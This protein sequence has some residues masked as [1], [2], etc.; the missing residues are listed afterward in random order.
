MNTTAETLAA[1]AEQDD[2]PRGTRIG[3]RMIPLDDLV[4]HPLNS[5]VMPEDLQAEARAHIKKSGRYPFL[6]VGSIRTSA[7]STAGWTVTIASPSSGTSAI[8]GRAAIWEVNDREALPSGHAQP[9]QDQPR[10]ALSLPRNS[11]ARCPR[12]PW[13]PAS[14]P[15][16]DKQIE[17]LH[18]FAE[19]PAERLHPSRSRPRQPEKVRRG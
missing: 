15:E 1:G 7:G 3:P 17:E 9:S 5:N 16:T 4:A 13:R 10:S 12:R 19:F 18:A 14:C 8:R 11:W 2:L 6:V